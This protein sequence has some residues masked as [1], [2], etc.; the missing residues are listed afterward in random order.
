MSLWLGTPVRDDWAAQ[1]KENRASALI[2]T[3]HTAAWPAKPRGATNQAPWC[4]HVQRG[5]L[6]H[7]LLEAGLAL[8]PPIPTQHPLQP[9]QV[10][11]RAHLAAGEQYR[12]T[13]GGAALPLAGPPVM[14]RR[15]LWSHSRLSKATGRRG[16][17]RAGS[18]SVGPWITGLGVQQSP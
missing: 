9:C 2:I 13:G 11:R 18:L 6:S 15:Y 8:Y 1:S 7:R 5:I 3:G 16:P 10:P 12:P 14:S 17:F 4:T